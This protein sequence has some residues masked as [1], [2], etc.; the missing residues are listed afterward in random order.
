MQDTHTQFKQSTHT[1][2]HKQQGTLLSQALTDTQHTNTKVGSS[3]PRYT[4][5]TYVTR[6]RTHPGRHIIIVVGFL[7]IVSSSLLLSGLEGAELVV[8]I[9]GADVWT[10]PKQVLLLQR[11]TFCFASGGGVCVRE[12]RVRMYARGSA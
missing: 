1:R 11:D 10:G 4:T 2:L 6:T 7:T 9:L 3:Q 12:W 8:C 5:H